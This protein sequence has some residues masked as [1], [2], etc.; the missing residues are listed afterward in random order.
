MS[1][2]AQTKRR[3]KL[4]HRDQFSRFPDGTPLMEMLKAGRAHG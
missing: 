1:K 4:A 2:N 3:A